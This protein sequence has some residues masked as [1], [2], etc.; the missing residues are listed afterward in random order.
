MCTFK[1][2]L[3]LKY[4]KQSDDMIDD[5]DDY[6]NIFFELIKKLLCYY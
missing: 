6:F 2:F 3:Q 5:F 1:Y 4:L